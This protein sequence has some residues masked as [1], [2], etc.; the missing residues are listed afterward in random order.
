MDKVNYLNS[1]N[2]LTNHHSAAIELLL[3]NAGKKISYI[4][5]VNYIENFNWTIP[6]SWLD[7]REITFDSNDLT[8]IAW[9][10]NYST[11]N[12]LQVAEFNFD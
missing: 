8:V 1:Y 4:G 10:Q 3:V 11:K 9:I 7:H 12:I 5:S 6:D 2:G